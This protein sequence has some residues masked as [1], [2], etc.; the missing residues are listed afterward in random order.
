MW[1]LQDTVKPS[2]GKKQHANRN[3]WYCK[4][5]FD[6]AGAFDRRQRKKTRWS[7]SVQRFAGEPECRS[8]MNQ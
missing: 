2:Y 1:Q 5:L 8:K 3:S 4:V 7:A 6:S